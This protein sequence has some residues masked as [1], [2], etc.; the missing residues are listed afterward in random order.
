MSLLLI[1]TLIYIAV[2]VLALA[3]SLILILVNL[4]RISRRLGE[5]QTSLQNVQTLTAPLSGPLE[6][7]QG[8]GGELHTGLSQVGDNLSQADQKLAALAS[9]L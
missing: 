7:L 3:V 6:L 8:A 9:R 5:V 4:I 1:L 2:L